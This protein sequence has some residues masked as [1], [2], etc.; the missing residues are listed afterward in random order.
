MLGEKLGLLPDDP[1]RIFS[2]LPLLTGVRA[3][4][5]CRLHSTV[6]FFPSAEFRRYIRNFDHDTLTQL[7]WPYAPRQLTSKCE[8]CG[9][10]KITE[11]T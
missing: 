6:A 9:K 7:T 4:L 1:N 5:V 2:F 3:G 8:Y 11:I 10:L